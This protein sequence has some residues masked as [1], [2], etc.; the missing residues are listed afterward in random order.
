[1]KT[2]L[3]CCN[4]EKP[5]QSLFILLPFLLFLIYFQLFHLL[6]V[7]FLFYFEFSI[8]HKYDL[9]IRFLHKSKKVDK[10][11]KCKTK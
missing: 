2:N 5:R 3:W 8:L 11:P 10:E 4:E 7:G 6:F 9:L 1:M